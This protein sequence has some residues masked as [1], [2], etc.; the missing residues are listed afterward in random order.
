MEQERTA[1][2]RDKRKKAHDDVRGREGGREEGREEETVELVSVVPCFCRPLVLE[3]CRKF[4]N[5]RK[6]LKRYVS[7]LPSHGLIKKGGGERRG[8]QRVGRWRRKEGEE[9]ECTNVLLCRQ[10]LQQ[11]GLWML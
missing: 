9:R 7:H 11:R 3:K 5:W 6:T 10:G 8:E 4:P 1:E 2:E